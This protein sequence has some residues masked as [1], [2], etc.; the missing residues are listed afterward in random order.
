MLALGSVLDGPSPEYILQEVGPAYGSIITMMNQSQ[1]SRVR[2]TA[3]WVIM[4]LVTHSP[5][6]IFSSQDNLNLLIE[7]GLEHIEHDHYLI[8]M[9]IAEAW[10]FAFEKASQMP[11][12]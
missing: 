12:P 9:H 10:E 5:M 1:S 4:L 8:R 6:L 2:K 7:K 3:A 11:T